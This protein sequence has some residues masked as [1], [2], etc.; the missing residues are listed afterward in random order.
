MGRKAKTHC[1]ECGIFLTKDIKVCG[2]CSKCAQRKS[3][4]WR[5][6]LENPKAYTV[7]N[8]RNGLAKKS[9]LTGRVE[10]EDWLKQIELFNSSCAYCLVKIEE[11]LN[12]DHVI[13]LAGGGEHA[14]NNV[15]PCCD[16]CNSV[17]FARGPLAMVNVPGPSFAENKIGNISP[18]FYRT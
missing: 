18:S 4:D 1:T 16:H 15:V 9:G 8:V 5:E 14:I 7:C 10:Y 11:N 3:S 2:K 13:P 6:R 12:M 17:K